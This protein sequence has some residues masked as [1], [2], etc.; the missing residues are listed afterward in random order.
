MRAPGAPARY[1]GARSGMCARR[2][3]SPPPHCPVRHVSALARLITAL[4]THKKGRSIT[5]DE[6]PLLLSMNIIASG[7][8]VFNS[9]CAGVT[10]GT[11]PLVT[12]SR[13][14]VTSGTVPIVTFFR[15]PLNYY[16]MSHFLHCINVSVNASAQEISFFHML[17]IFCPKIIHILVK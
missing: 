12:I 8:E 14:N 11:V 13:E 10:T 1:H 16:S 15:V 9:K 4:I 2:A 17:L 7:T 5:M 6:T 3:C